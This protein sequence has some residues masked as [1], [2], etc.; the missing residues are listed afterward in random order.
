MSVS[1]AKIQPNPAKKTRRGANTPIRPTGEGVKHTPK[2]AFAQSTQTIAHRRRN[3]PYFCSR[4]AARPRH[5]KPKPH[6][7]ATPADS[8]PARRKSPQRFAA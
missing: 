7:S 2:L 4:F 6:P 8:A 1:S 5:A 3:Q